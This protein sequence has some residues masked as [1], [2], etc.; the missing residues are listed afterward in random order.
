MTKPKPVFISPDDLIARATTRGKTLSHE[1]AE[2]LSQILG[3]NRVVAETADGRGDGTAYDMFHEFRD[4]DTYMGV[5]E[6][7]PTTLCVS[8]APTRGRTS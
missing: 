3:P 5:Y 4:L 8:G 1:D 2:V 6:E 7:T